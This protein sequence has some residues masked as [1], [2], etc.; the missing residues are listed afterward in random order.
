MA[1]VAVY[2]FYFCFNTMNRSYSGKIKASAFNCG[3]ISPAQVSLF[4]I[5]LIYIN[6]SEQE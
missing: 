2:S 1:P 5:I 3:T 4:E 6:V